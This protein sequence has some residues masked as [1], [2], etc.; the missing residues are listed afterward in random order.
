MTIVPNNMDAMPDDKIAAGTAASNA[1]LP[2]W[3]YLVGAGMLFVFA[4]TRLYTDK[5]ADYAVQLLIVWSAVALWRYR[6][7]LRNALVFHLFLLAVLAQLLTWGLGLWLTPELAESSPKVERLGAWFF[8]LPVALFAGGTPRRVLALWG[9]SFAALLLAP[10]LSGQGWDE[11]L[12]GLAGNR[13]GFGIINEQHMGVLFG[14]AFLGLG[15]F[16]YRFQCYARAIGAPWL[17]VPYTLLL[18]ASLVAVVF[19]QTRAVWLALLLTFAVLTVVVLC[20]L[21][22]ERRTTYRAALREMRWRVGGMIALMVILVTALLSSIIVERISNEATSAAVLS[23]EVES[24]QLEGSVRVRLNTWWEA[25]HWIAERPLFG[26]G[27]NGR[28]EVVQASSGLSDSD[29]ERFRHLHSTYMDALVN[30][31][32]AGLLLWFALL[33]WLSRAI[34]QAWASAG[35]A[36]D[37]CW[38]WCAFLVFWLVVNAFESYMFY[39]SG[40]YAFA[41]VAGGYLSLL[42]RKPGES[43]ERPVAAPIA[44]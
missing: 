2:R 15:I 33:W 21:N 30:Y 44:E 6:D 35:L 42:A 16:L 10:W 22:P 20:A 32:L 43:I 40:F 38:F 41:L 31:G 17:L 19:S 3:F 5:L 37:F 4:C 8:L 14:I 23:G 34:V 36:D 29:R 12:R 1:S 18:L 9:V 25:V 7:P 24:L 39:E 28:S 11:V 26:W 27:G 13:V